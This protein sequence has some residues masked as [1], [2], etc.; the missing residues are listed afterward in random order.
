MFSASGGMVCRTQRVDG[1][2]NARL[3]GAT[4]AGSV[5]SPPFGSGGL[6]R[7]ISKAET[8]SGLLE[9]M[10]NDIGETMDF[11]SY[12]YDDEP[13]SGCA[14][15][16]LRQVNQELPQLCLALQIATLA[17]GFCE[18]CAEF[19]GRLHGEIEDGVLFL[20]YAG[21]F[22]LTSGLSERSAKVTS[23]PHPCLRRPARSRRL[24]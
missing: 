12:Y 10:T 20:G 8:H 7:A 1:F 19:L 6:R 14:V 2:R 11:E 22:G 17:R 21:L 18:R 5:E 15:C 4:P 16:L 9:T 23:S 13:G 24:K 3:A